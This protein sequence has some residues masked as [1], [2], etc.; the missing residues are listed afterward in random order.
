[1]KNHREMVLDEQGFAFDPSS[2]Q[3][4]R[5]NMTGLAILRMFQ[6]DQDERTIAEALSHRFKVALSEARRDVQDFR[7]RLKSL[8]IA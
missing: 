2:G 3:C 6:S 5:V 8:G 1:M 7:F 4:F